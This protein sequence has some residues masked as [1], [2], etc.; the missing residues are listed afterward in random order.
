M[1]R[2]IM[3]LFDEYLRRGGNI[4]RLQKILGHSSIKTTELYLAFLT[5]EEQM[6]AQHGMADVVAIG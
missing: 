1:M 6:Q 4:Y 5:P 3:A 2:Q